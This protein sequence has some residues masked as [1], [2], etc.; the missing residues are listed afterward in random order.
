[1]RSSTL[2]VVLILRASLIILRASLIA[3][4]LPAP[5]HSTTGLMLPMTCLF[6]K[7]ALYEDRWKLIRDLVP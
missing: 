5:D 2:S 7:I 3:S 6:D 1:M 4:A